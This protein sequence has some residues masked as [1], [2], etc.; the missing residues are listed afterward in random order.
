MPEQNEIHITDFLLLL[1]MLST[2]VSLKWQLDQ[3]KQILISF[4]VIMQVRK[5]PLKFHFPIKCITACNCLL[6]LHEVP[7]VSAPCLRNA[8]N[9]SIFANGSQF[10]VAN[11]VALF[12]STVNLRD[13]NL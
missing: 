7:P 4:T 3:T 5:S 10:A 12:P 2:D 9:T 11:E 1:F 8:R 13:V 6:Y